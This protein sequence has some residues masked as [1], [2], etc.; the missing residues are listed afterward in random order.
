[1]KS[2]ISLFAVVLLALPSGAQQPNTAAASMTFN[3][4]N[5]PSLPIVLPINVQTWGPVLALEISGAPNRGFALVTAPAGVIVPGIPTQFGIV[6]LDLSGGFSILLDGLGLEAP[7]LLS[8]ISN[9][10]PSGTRSFALTVTAASAGIAAGLQCLVEDPSSASGFRLTAATLLT[11]VDAPANAVFVSHSRGAPGNPGTAGFPFLTYAEGINAALAAGVPYPEVRIEHGSYAITGSLIF[12]AG[13]SVTGGL[14]PIGWVHV[15]GTY[16]TIDVGTEPADIE[17]AVAPTTIRGME[18]IASGV[19]RNEASIAL[20]AKD[21]SALTFIACRFQSAGG[22]DATAGAPGA[23]GAN[24]G[25][26][27]MP[28]G[29]GNPGGVHGNGHPNDGGNGGAGGGVGSDGNNGVAGQG[30]GGAGGPLS[31]GALCGGTNNASGGGNGGAAANGV[32]GLVIY[33]PG[34]TLDGDTWYPGSSGNGGASGGPGKGGGGGGGSGG[35]GCTFSSGNGGGGGGGGGEGGGGGGPGPN[36]GASFAVHL[37]DSIAVFQDCVFATGDGGDGGA[38]GAGAVGGSGGTGALGNSS[39]VTN[40]GNGGKGG[41]GSAGGKGGG[42]PGGHGG[43]SFGVFKSG[44]SAV[45]LNG[46]NVFNVGS[47]GA[48]GSGGTAPAGGNAGQAGSP[49]PSGSVN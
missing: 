49:G 20:W 3:G 21:S 2:L 7:N 15:P 48:P 6:D 18:V 24:G 39:S 30:P 4:I 27:S 29:N 12:H 44:T 42:G 19:G 1:M 8:F 38:G 34:G 16:S 23:S 25:N 13:M 45:T 47:G 5:G 36:G 41:N 17:G 37:H 11:I 9:T 31:A 35:N 32:G 33:L 22:P 28:G 10:S 43:P 46:N 26:G 40:V 14:D